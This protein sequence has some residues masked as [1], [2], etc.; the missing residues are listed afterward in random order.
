MMI[1]VW[2]PEYGE[3]EEEAAA[4][5][6]G[7][8]E[9]CEAA[10]RD[11]D[12]HAGGFTHG[13]FRVRARGADGQIWTVTV[14]SWLSRE[15]SARPHH[16]PLTDDQVARLEALS[17]E[18]RCEVETPSSFADHLRAESGQNEGQNGQSEI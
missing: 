17:P 6:G 16:P 10:C 2:F 1:E 9:A 15:Y 4:F 7:L 12:E 18:D 14:E 13:G 3:T 8:R 11:F 5:P